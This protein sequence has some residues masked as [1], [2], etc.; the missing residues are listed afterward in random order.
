MD[1]HTRSKLELALVTPDAI[2]V[3]NQVVKARGIYFVLSYMSHYPT[4]FVGTKDMKAEPWMVVD[5]RKKT[6]QKFKLLN[7]DAALGLDDL[8]DRLLKIGLRVGLMFDCNK[9]KQKFVS[10]RLIPTGGGA[11]TTVL[12]RIKKGEQRE[13]VQFTLNERW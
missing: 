3:W 1:K 7:R 9:Q 12:D 6:I 4:L 10:L 11:M 2:E 13:Y 5:T 8:Q